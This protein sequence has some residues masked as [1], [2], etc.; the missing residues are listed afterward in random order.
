MAKSEDKR[1]ADDITKELPRT[2]TP[3]HRTKTR[4][5]GKQSTNRAERTTHAMNKPEEKIASDENELTEFTSY[6]M[7]K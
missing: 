6:K 4:K 7:N 2:D 3:R 1:V 5:Y